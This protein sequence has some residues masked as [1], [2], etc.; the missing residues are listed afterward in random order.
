MKTR[1]TGTLTDT[2]LSS[3]ELAFVQAGKAEAGGE[4]GSTR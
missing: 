3:S 2:R 1:K 4:F